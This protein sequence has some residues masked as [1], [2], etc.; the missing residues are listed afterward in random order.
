[1]TA[2]LTAADH[3]TSLTIVS[4]LIGSVNTSAFL[5]TYLVRLPP[6]V[7]QK[8]MGIHGRASQ[9]PK[10]STSLGLLK[11]C[12]PQGPKITWEQRAKAGVDA[13]HFQAALAAKGGS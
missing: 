6:V 3:T 8:A 9:Y 11:V 7:A 1:V 10:N 5:V 4:E 2:F 13:K 12:G